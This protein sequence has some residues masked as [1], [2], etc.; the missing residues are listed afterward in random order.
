M[1]C[2]WQSCLPLVILCVCVCFVGSDDG[3]VCVC[4]CVCVCGACVCGA[5]VCACV[6]VYVLCVYECDSSES[7]S[8][9]LRH[10]DTVRFNKNDVFSANKGLSGFVRSCSGE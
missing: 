2:I 3:V 6:R 10:S 1:N 9:S 5:C 8:M 4:V 7:V